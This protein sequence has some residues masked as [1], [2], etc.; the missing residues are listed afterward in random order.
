MALKK[1][2]D[3]FTKQTNTSEEYPLPISGSLS[4]IKEQFNKVEE[5]KKQLEGVTNSI[6][7]S[8][9]EV[10]DSN[11]DLIAFKNE[12][13]ELLNEFSSKINNIEEDFNNKINELK[14]SQLDLKTGIEIVETRQSKVNIFTM[15][16]EIKEELSKSGL[17][18]KLHGEIYEQL[19]SNISDNIKKLEGKVQNIKESYRKIQQ[20]HQILNEGLLNEPPAIDNEDPLTPLDKKFVT[21]DKFQEHYN[22]FVNRIQKQLSTLGGGGAVNI[23]DMD[24]IDRSSAMVNGKVLE[25]DSS[26]GKW[27]GGD[28]TGTVTEAF[29]NIA[30]S[31]QSDIVADASTDTLNIVGGTNVTITTNA[32]TDT[33]TINAATGGLSNLVEDTTPQLGGNLDVNNKNIVLS[34]SNSITQNRVVLGHD[35]DF[36][37]FFAGTDSM[38]DNNT[39]DLILRSN[40]NADVGGNIR[41]QPKPGENG[42]VI[43]HDASVE[44]YENNI[45]KIETTTDGARI[46]GG[47]QDKD[48]NLGT[49]GQ[50]LSSTGTELDWITPSDT[51][52][53]TEEVQDIVGAMFTGNTE[54]NITATYQDSDGTID[55]VASSGSEITVQDEGSS[56]STAA[57]TLNFT[58]A[59]VVAS[60]TGAT[61]TI[62]ISGTTLTTEAVQ[63]IVGAMF[64][65]NTETNITATYEDSDGTIDLVAT[66]GGA[67]SSRA[68]NSAS[69]GSIAQTASANI[70][71]NTQSKTFALLKVAISAPAWVVL[72]VDSASRS[73][74]SSRTEGT[75]PAPG[76]GVIT[77]VSTTTSGA[78][79]FLMSPGVIGWNNDST[80]AAQIYAKVT[81]KRATSG[82]NAITVTL[83][84]MKLEA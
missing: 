57:T 60:G 70:T 9:S 55:L 40:V 44:L 72:Y 30:V 20:K 69:T 14:D 2:G 74:D 1:P 25:Y 41:L 28:G 58:G 12:Y 27:K 24:D 64:T 39:G 31:G 16:K 62:N 68:D 17:T 67:L 56:L 10:V 79:T 37:I 47:L 8:L 51:Q 38:I 54:T 84:N 22:L 15:R 23:R 52:L 49:S 81:N 45:K 82:S 32:T 21:L 63:D 6:D 33:L 78:S 48:G 43:T 80:P 75:D 42:I 83:T 7:N 36:H 66:A 29:K 71:I 53:S 65:G 34:D 77:E 19:I 4:N 18:D 3:L 73:A 11:L 5:L 46:Y 59:G 61:K 35:S 50:V 26:T 76:A 13:S